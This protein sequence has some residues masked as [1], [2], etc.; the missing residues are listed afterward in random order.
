MY[1]D[2]IRFERLRKN[3]LSFDSV[4]YDSDSENSFMVFFILFEFEETEWPCRNS[5]FLSV[6]AGGNPL[7]DSCPSPPKKQ[8]FFKKQ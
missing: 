7:N 8:L 6:E 4:K 1:S 5:G 3:I 2:F